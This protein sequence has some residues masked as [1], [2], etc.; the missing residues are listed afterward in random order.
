MESSS[1]IGVFQDCQKLY[2]Y[3]YEKLLESRGYSSPMGL[4]TLVHAFIEQYSGKG[5]A[6]AAEQE[7][8]SLKARSSEEFHPQIE[9]D[10]KLSIELSKLWREYW[11]AST[12][13]FGNQAFT[14][15]EAESEWKFKIGNVDH[16]GKRDGLLRHKEWNKI[17][18]YEFK[19]A[20]ATGVDTY[21]NRL[22]MDRQISSNIL[23]LKAEGVKVDGVVYDV[24]FKPALR[25][26]KD[27][28]TKPDE[29][30]EE[31]SAR[32]VAAIA[33][34]KQ[35]YFQRQI[36]YRTEQQLENHSSDIHHVFESMETA[37]LRNAW[38]RNTNMCDNFG[39]LCPFFSMCLGTASEA[40]LELQ[41]NKRSRKL[42][43]LSEALNNGNT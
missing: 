5:R 41:F 35:K 40:D 38:P 20:T 34:D 2:S 4:G 12:H 37:R 13:P 42:P 14:W 8:L 3:K 6:D 18:L 31:F 26:L 10:Y 25:L 9:S 7:Y 28:K 30:Q 32:L 39:K 29:T 36:V 22:E 15:L 24:L 19:T 33:D 11:A 27:R 21:F 1:S 23:A 16:V 17:F 43:E